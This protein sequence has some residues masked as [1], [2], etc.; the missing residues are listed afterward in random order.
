MLIPHTFDEENH[1]YLVS[2]EFVLSTSA[3]IEMNGL[4]DLSQIPIQQVARAGHRGSSLHAAIL[5]YETDCDVQDCVEGYDLKHNVYLANEVMERFKFYL[6]WRGEHDVQL[7]GKMEDRRVYRHEGTEQLIGATPDFPCLIDG[8]FYILDGKTSHKNYGEKAKQDKLK[9]RLQLQSYKES[10]EAEDVPKEIKKAIL[11]LHP[12]CG[13]TGVKGEARGFEFHEFPADDSHLWDAA[14]RMASAKLANGY[15]MTLKNTSGVDL[16]G[17]RPDE[18]TGKPEVWDAGM[19]IT[20]ADQP[21]WMQ[22]RLEA[23]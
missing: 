5:A 13:K 16:S 21:S 12:T 20:D 14:I 17:M 8:E 23:E 7:V 19:E 15:K 22:E 3:V 18:S 9:W 6:R 11:H 1:L 4:S 2:G 10:H